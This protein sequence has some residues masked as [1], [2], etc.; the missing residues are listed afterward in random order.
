MLFTPEN[1]D[2]VRNGILTQILDKFQNEVLNPGNQE[3]SN[4]GSESNTR[5]GV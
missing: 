4:Q 1:Q 5:S 2:S 3:G